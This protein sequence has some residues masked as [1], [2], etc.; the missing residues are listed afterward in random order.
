MNAIC[1][2][3]DRLHA[4]YLGAYG[5]TWMET[6]ALDRLAGQSF[7][8]DQAL[9]D[10]PL[11]EPQCRSYWQGWHAL[12]PPAQDRATLPAVLRRA[13][14]TTALVTDE[15]LVRRH[16]LAADF[17]EIVEI[18]PPGEIHLAGEGEFHQTHLARCFAQ[19][20]DWLGAARGPF[21]LWCHLAGL[22]TT[23]DA[24]M[25]F[26]LRY[27]EESDP[28]PGDSARV[29]ELML[30]ERSDPDELL[31]HVQAYAGQVS[32]WDACL[33][34]LLEALDDTP[35]GAE[36]LLA[37]GSARGFPLG[38]H[39]RVGPCD[40]ALYGELVQVPLLLRFPGG[41][42]AAA[43]SQALVEPGDLWAT[44]LDCW[45]LP[46]AAACPSAQSLMPIVRGERDA[47]RDR[48]CIAGGQ[49]ER[50]IRTPAWHLRT[51]RSTANPSPELFVKPD[52][53]WEANDVSNRCQEVVEC[54]HL[55]LEQCEQAIRVGL[56]SDLPPL[57]DVL[58]NGLEQ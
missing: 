16:P 17:D 26:R 52:D 22:G 51:G 56:A 8:F 39:R 30:G 47:L 45:Q 37:L 40:A 35:A 18:D 57:S 28:E 53:R 24:P 41:L 23:W 33:A 2:I 5:N 10:T 58:V 55:A 3:T 46:G 32:L 38:E 1:L 31:C 7:V 12:C 48:I 20:V 34:A 9:I 11:L 19:L 54:L 42:G 15:P 6:P 44:L 43:R 50:A 36:T 49:T 13:G 14:V 27:R 29:P 21:L 4:G 25:D